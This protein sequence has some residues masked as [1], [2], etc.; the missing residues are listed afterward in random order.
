MIGTISGKI[1]EK[2]GDSLLIEIGGIGYEIVVTVT[3]WG[4]AK[5][6]LPTK[7]YIYEHIREDAHTLFGFSSPAAK[8]L[9]MRLLSVSGVGPKV[10]MQV[11]SAASLERLQQA[12]FSGDVDLLKGVSGVGKKTAERIMVEL[13]GKIEAGGAALAGSTVSSSDAA[14]QALLGLGYTPAQAAAALAEVSSDITEDNQ[15]VKAA[16]QVIK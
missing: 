1:V 6:G 8:Q 15:R 11:M 13:K 4:N 14:Y 10:A 5:I 7:L 16:L 2:V 3:D 12:I 9:F